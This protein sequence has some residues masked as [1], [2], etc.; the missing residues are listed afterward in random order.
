MVGEINIACGTC[1]FCLRG[2]ENHCPTRSVLGIKRKN[3]A[4]AEYLTLPLKNLHE[5]P[6]AIDD[7][8][9]VFVE[10][11]AAALEILEQVR[12]GEND[13]VLILGDGK[14]GLLA[15]QVIKSQT[16]RV[17]CAGKHQ[18]K[19]NILEKKRIKIFCGG[20][21]IEGQFDIVIEATGKKEGVKQALSLV[22][23]RGRIVLKSTF[24]DDV[25][26]DVSSIVIGEIELIGSRCGPFSKAISV[27]ANR[28]IDVVEMADGD[29][30]LNK[31]KEALALAQRPEM[32]KVLITP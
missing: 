17:S 25:N 16:D 31:A 24:C 6:Q 32:I 21:A 14:L 26:V 13:S 28:E 22:K 4:F 5:I 7:Q 30:P 12:I 3:G 29:F 8:E 9:A 15:A 27:L 10:P 11:L 2:L 19:L 23:P 18:R 20:E 1:D